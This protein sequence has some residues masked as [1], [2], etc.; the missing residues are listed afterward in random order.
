MVK[1]RQRGGKAK[2]NFFI[3]GAAKAAT[4]SLASLL[5]EH[6]EAAIVQRKEPHFFSEDLNYAKG[7]KQYL[8]MYSHCRNELAIGDASTSYS[9]I[10][11]HPHTIARIKHHVPKAK[12]IY[13][14]RHPIERMVSAYIEHISTPGSLAPASINDAV[15]Q[16]PAIIHSSRYWEV[17]QAYRGVFP[18]SDIKVVWF[19]DYVDDTFAVFQDVCRFLGIDAEWRPD[20]SAENKNSK[21][22]TLQRK[23]KIGREDLKVSLEWDETLKQRIIAELKDDTVSLLQHFNRQGTYWSDLD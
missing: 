23:N 13:M 9:R 17:Y 3:I 5:S 7:Y 15:L 14:V 2:P 8:A 20:L 16:I 10:R 19:E 1:K 22:S 12:I 6:P 4:T 21:E 11:Q 18:E